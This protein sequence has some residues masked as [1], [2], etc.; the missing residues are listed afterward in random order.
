[1]DPSSR[2]SLRASWREV[3]QSLP[4]KEVLGIGDGTSD[5]GEVPHQRD[6][7]EVSWQAE[8]RRLGRA[9]TSRKA[10]LTYPNRRQPELVGIV[11]GRRCRRDRPTILVA[12]DTSGSMMRPQLEQVGAELQA[13]LRM[14]ARVAVVQCD[15]KIQTHGRMTSGDRLTRALGRGGTDL[16]PPFVK[17]IF[18]HYRPEAI[19]YFTDGFGL[20]PKSPPAGLA[21]LWVLTGRQTRNPAG[22]GRSVSMNPPTKGRWS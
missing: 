1:M 13:I 16:R 3:A 20:A 9:A 10:T 22:W 12:I 2:V 19:V 8:L 6:N 15:M 11:P 5:H 17:E 14:G 21:V 7:A 4:D 18:A